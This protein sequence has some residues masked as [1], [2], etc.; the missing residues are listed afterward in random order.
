MPGF[1]DVLDA[2]ADPDHQ[3][4]QTAFTWLGDYNPDTIDELPIKYAL[5][6]I[7]ARRNAARAPLAKTEKPEPRSPAK[8]YNAFEL[9]ADV[10]RSRL[11]EGPTFFLVREG[12]F[13][14]VAKNGD[15][16]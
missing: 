11:L 4:H 12:L 16:L 1:Y 7:A 9:H 3:G 13:I 8:A 2:R 14:V 15:R 6:R 10:S 5:G